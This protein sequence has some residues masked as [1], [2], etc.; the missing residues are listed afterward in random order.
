M[1]ESSLSSNPVSPE[2]ASDGE[3]AEAATSASDARSR[4]LLE[5]LP[6][7]IWT[8]RP[9]GLCDY[10]SPQWAQYTGIPAAELLGYGWLEQVHPEDRQPTL[11]RWQEVAGRGET[12]EVEFRIRRR[13]GVYRWFALRAIPLRDE[14]GRIVCWL[15]TSTDIDDRRRAEEE[16]EQQREALRTTL[17][18]IGDAVIATDT[19]GRVTFMNRVAEELTGWSQHGATSQLLPSVFQIVDEGTRSPVTNPVEEVFKTGRVVGL[20]IHTIL[21][22]RDGQE[23]AIDDSAAPIRN[24]TGALL[25]AVLTFRDVTERRRL[26]VAARRLAAVVESSDDAIVSKDLNGIVTSW[27][28]AAERIFGYSAEE[29]IGQPIARLIPPERPDEEPAILERIRKGDRIDHY[30]T[31]RMRKDGTRF[32]VSVTISPVKDST[33]RIVGASKVARDISHAR[34]LRSELERRVAELAEADRRKDQFLAM[35]AHE[36]RNPLGAIS[37]AVHVLDQPQVSDATRLRAVEVL[38]R[39]VQHQTRIVNELLDVSRITLG[40]VELRPEQ[41]DLVRLVREVADDYRLA[42]QR[43][44]ITLQLDLPEGPLRMKADHTRLAQVVSNLLSNALKFTPAGG[45]VTVAVQGSADSAYAELTVTDTGIGIEPE[46]LPRVFE[47]FTQGDRTLV[48]SRGGLGLGLAI[49]KGLVALHDGEV[50]AESRGEGTGTTLRVVLPLLLGDA[51]APQGK[52]AGPREGGGL[53][54]LVIEDHE[55]AAEMLK[56]LLELYGYEARIALSGSEGVRVAREYHPDVVLCD[57]GLPGMDGYEVAAELRRA[58]GGGRPRLVAVTGYGREEDRRR[59]R[60]AGFQYH[61]VK[62]IDPQELCAVLC[63]L[64]EEIAR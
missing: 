5:A 44:Q 42:F 64:A 50:R 29:M 4:Q 6:Q 18:S 46:L 43:D 27:N 36:L 45:R 17:E 10:L 58:P 56:V 53:R 51:D 49:V 28:K 7:L 2:A 61:L 55:D 52:A 59:S 63:T 22:A 14:A 54:V 23:R 15:G 11:D 62:P 8:C 26:E 39:Q 60:E 13:D 24:R 32:D 40:L 31:V 37:N 47:T 30:E 20:A 19:S 57:L 1:S 12:F 48:R 41:L 25:G 21:I 38:R 9:D 34:A 33:G 3:R 35:L 16:A